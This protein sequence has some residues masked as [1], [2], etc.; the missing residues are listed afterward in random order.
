MNLKNLRQFGLLALLAPPACSAM[1][2]CAVEG[3]DEQGQTE[4]ALAGDKSATGQ[5]TQYGIT[6]SKS[7]D[8]GILIGPIN[9]S[10]I[11]QLETDLGSMG[12]SCTVSGGC[13]HFYN[14]VGQAPGAGTFPTDDV[15]SEKTLRAVIREMFAANP[16]IANLHVVTL[17]GLTAVSDARTGF[18]TLDGKSIAGGTLAVSYL[19]SATNVGLWN[20]DLGNSTHSWTARAGRFPGQSPVVSAIAASDYQSGAIDTVASVSAAACSAVFAAQAYEP[21]CAGG[22][23]SAADAASVAV[24]VPVFFNGSALNVTDLHAP[25]GFWAGR[26]SLQTLGMATRADIFA[27]AATKHTDVTT[28]TDSLS[29]TA[30]AGFDVPSGIGAPKGNLTK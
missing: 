19:E 9:D 20:T 7:V 3:P 13:L 25:A 6:G 15:P 26:L 8:L 28:G 22:M 11:T 21:G 12:I 1:Q 27:G 16:G 4:Q 14:Q 17:N 2:G 23:R 18:A 29:H 5:R 24:D 30:A 10:K